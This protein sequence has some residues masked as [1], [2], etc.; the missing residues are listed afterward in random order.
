MQKRRPVPVWVGGAR[1]SMVRLRSP[2]AQVR[3]L[4]G[5]HVDGSPDVGGHARETAL[6]L[7]PRFG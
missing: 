6:R 4:A 7:P 3:L 1:A 5:G 2:L